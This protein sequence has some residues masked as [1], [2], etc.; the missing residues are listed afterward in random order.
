MAPVKS[1]IN[2]PP[3]ST[4][5]TALIIDNGLSHICVARMQVKRLIMLPTE[6]SIPPVSMITDCDI[7]ARNNGKSQADRLLTVSMP[8]VLRF[9]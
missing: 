8:N 2:A 1:P 3:A 5:V 6:R 9:I 4:M 7:A